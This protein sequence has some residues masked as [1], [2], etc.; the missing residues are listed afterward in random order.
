[1]MKSHRDLSCPR[2]LSVLTVGIFCQSWVLKIEMSFINSFLFAE[3]KL[4]LME[5]IF[6][7]D[8][9][10]VILGEILVVVIISSLY[11]HYRWWAERCM[12]DEV[13]TFLKAFFLK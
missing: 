9:T 10:L 4:E 11:R 8:V 2:R 12:G 13:T 5:D 3:G 7:S 6:L 1:M